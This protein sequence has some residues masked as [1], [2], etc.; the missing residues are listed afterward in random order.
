MTAK[1]GVDHSDIPGFLEVPLRRV[2]G[3]NWACEVKTFRSSI[4]SVRPAA[5]Q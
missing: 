5:A 3:R 1:A 2:P 4:D